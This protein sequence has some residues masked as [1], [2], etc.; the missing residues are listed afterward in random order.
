MRR[1]RAQTR[2]WLHVRRPDGGPL[3]QTSHCECR[4]SHCGENQTRTLNGFTPRRLVSCSP[5]FREPGA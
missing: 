1:E 2:T 5:Q 4:V 3:W